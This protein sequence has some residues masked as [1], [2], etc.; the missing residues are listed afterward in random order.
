[1]YKDKYN[2]NE[3]VEKI[4]R[5]YSNEKIIGFL[6]VKGFEEDMTVLIGEDGEPVA[7]VDLRPWK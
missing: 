2:K 4:L 7:I 6:P 5:I 1:M 3:N